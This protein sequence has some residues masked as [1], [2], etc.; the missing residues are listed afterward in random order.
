MGLFD[1]DEPRTSRVHELG[2]SLDGLSIDDLDRRI[3]AL[4]EEITRLEDDKRAKERTRDAAAAAFKPTI[5]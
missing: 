5:S 4:R 3:A 2:Q 1:G